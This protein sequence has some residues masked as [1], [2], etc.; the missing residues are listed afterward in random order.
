MQTTLQGYRQIFALYDNRAAQAIVIILAG[1]ALLWNAL[2][3][4]RAPFRSMVWSSERLS[5]DTTG[6]PHRALR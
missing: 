3:Q 4:A 5:T 1:W 2:D 6:T